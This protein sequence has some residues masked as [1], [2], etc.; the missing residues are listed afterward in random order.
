MGTM[1]ILV[2]YGTEEQKARWLVP[3]LEGRIHSCFAMTDRKV[4]CLFL[5][6]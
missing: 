6:L 2:R 3:L 1:E 5:C 4:P